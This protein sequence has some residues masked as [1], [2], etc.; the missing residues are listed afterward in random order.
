MYAVLQLL[1]STFLAGLAVLLKILILPLQLM[2]TFMKRVANL[3]E[4]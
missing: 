2:S 1:D 4:R 3:L